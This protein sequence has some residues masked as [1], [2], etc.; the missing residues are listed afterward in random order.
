MKILNHSI[1]KIVLAFAVCATVFYFFAVFRNRKDIQTSGVTEFTSTGTFS[2]A[3]PPTKDNVSSSYTEAV[4]ELKHSIEKNPKN[5]GHLKALARLLMDGHQM[6]EA[7]PYLVQAAAREPKNDS[8]LFDLTACYFSA[9]MNDAALATTE[10]IL[11]LKHRIPEALYNKGIILAAQ[12]RTK[13]AENVWNHLMT[14]A[15]GSTEAK[16]A[17]AHFAQLSMK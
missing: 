13:E 6:K 17:R 10:K 2:P 9:N 5:A 7:I 11:V 16:K 3:G 8:L 1:V 12:R 14:I 15:P 4:A